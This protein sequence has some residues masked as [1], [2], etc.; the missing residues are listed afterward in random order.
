MSSR[1]CCNADT[2][3]A[4]HEPRQ[5]VTDRVPMTRGSGRASREHPAVSLNVA[6]VS[7]RRRGGKGGHSSSVLI[8]AKRFQGSWFWIRH[9]CRSLRIKRSRDE[10]RV[11]RTADL[12]FTPA[13]SSF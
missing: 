10:V 13:L 4:Q 2:P 6:L 1:K 3:I 12:R 8:S 7:S 11:R 9:F 5:V